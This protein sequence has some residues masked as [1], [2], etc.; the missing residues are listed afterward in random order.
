MVPLAQRLLVGGVFLSGVAAVGAVRRDLHREV[1]DVPDVAGVLAVQLCFHAVGPDLVVAGRAQQH[2]AVAR[3]LLGV[4]APIKLELEVVVPLGRADVADRVARALQAAIDDRPHRHL[5]LALQ[6]G[7]EGRPSRGVLAVEELDPLALRGR[8]GG[9][10]GGVIGSGH[11]HAAGKAG[12]HEGR[13]QGGLHGRD[14]IGA[15]EPAI[16]DAGRTAPTHPSS[17]ARPHGRSKRSRVVQ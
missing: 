12:Q 9:L 10:L 4:E 13:K 11:R 8:L 2:A 17:A 7:H 3:T 1:A 15:A 5:V 14:D 6:V 16:N